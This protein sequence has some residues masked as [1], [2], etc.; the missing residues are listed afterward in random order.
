MRVGGRNAEAEVAV[1][2]GAAPAAVWPTVPVAW[3]CRSCRASFRFEN[4]LVGLRRRLATGEA[5]DRLVADPAGQPLEEAD[6][7][8]VLRAAHRHGQDE[9]G[10]R[11]AG[12]P[13]SS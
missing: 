4:W 11:G 13:G 2:L 10:L 3:R 7:V 9:L 12:R 5:S 8:V 1:R 6:A